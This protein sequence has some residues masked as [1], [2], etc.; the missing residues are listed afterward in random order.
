MLWNKINSDKNINLHEPLYLE[1]MGDI[2]LSITIDNNVD[3][4]LVII[5]KSNYSI[6]ITNYDYIIGYRADDSY[7]RYAESFVYNTLPLKLSLFIL[8]H[9]DSFLPESLLP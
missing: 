1:I 8:L 9:P 7:F 4:K 6:D 3:T 5:S 2:R